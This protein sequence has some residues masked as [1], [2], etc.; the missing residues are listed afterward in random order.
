M[1]TMHFPMWR[2]LFNSAHDSFPGRGDIAVENTAHSLQRVSLLQISVTNSE[3]TGFKDS[4]DKHLVYT[5]C[6]ELPE[7]H[8][9][10]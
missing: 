8:R 5:L 2:A 1:R 10:L 9:A 7:T 6:R 3:Q 4:E